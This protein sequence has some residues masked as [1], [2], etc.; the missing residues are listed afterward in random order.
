MARD[1]QRNRAKRAKRI[2]A[3]IDNLLNKDGSSRTRRADGQSVPSLRELTDAAAAAAQ[4]EAKLKSPEN[5]EN[6]FVSASLAS[7]N[8]RTGS[9][10]K[11]S[12][13]IEPAES[14]V[15]GRSRVAAIA[16]SPCTSVV[17]R[18]A[19]LSCSSRDNAVSVAIPAA[20]ANGFPESVPA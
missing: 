1:D 20:I 6:I 2:R 11:N 14:A 8:D 12:P 18:V 9:A 5:R 15:N 3:E 13:H 4:A 17:V 19:I 16:R 10:R 7:L